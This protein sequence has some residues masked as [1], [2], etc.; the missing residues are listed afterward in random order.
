MSVLSFALLRVLLDSKQLNSQSHSG[1]WANTSQVCKRNTDFSI[2]G[3]S[4]PPRMLLQLGWPSTGLLGLQATPTLSTAIHL[5]SQ[6]LDSTPVLL[7]PASLLR[8]SHPCASSP[9]LASPVLLCLPRELFFVYSKVLP[10]A[11]LA[12]FFLVTVGTTKNKRQKLGQG[13]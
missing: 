1:R 4:F 11:F 6:T 5:S 13:I 9:P 7:S 3:G 2:Q 8:P 10:S 12:G